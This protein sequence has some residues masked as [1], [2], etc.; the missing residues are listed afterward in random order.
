MQKVIVVIRNHAVGTLGDLEGI[1]VEV[2]D[3]R[4]ESLEATDGSSWDQDEQGEWYVQHRFPT[5]VWDLI[6]HI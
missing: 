5:T 4:D 1:Q 3:Y 6:D 2:R